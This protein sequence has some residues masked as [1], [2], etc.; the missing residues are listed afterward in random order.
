MEV[1][2]KITKCNAPA[3]GQRSDG[4]E[5]RRSSVIVTYGEFEDKKFELTCWKD[6]E[7]FDR[8][9]MNTPIRFRFD[10]WSREYNGRWYTE[11]RAHSWEVLQY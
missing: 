11:A 4:T 3:G 2:A 7:S 8:L 10:L 5:W 6:T 9:P 1:I